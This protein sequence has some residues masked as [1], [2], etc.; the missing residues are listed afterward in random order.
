M[1]CQ[2]NSKTTKCLSAVFAAGLDW[3][4]EEAGTVRRSASRTYCHSA[5]NGT[6]RHGRDSRSHCDARVEN[7]S[8]RA[9]PGGF[10]CFAESDGTSSPHA[11][12]CDFL[13][14][15]SIGYRRLLQGQSFHSLQLP[16]A[17]ESAVLVVV[18]PGRSDLSS[19]SSSVRAPAIRDL[20]R[21]SAAW[22]RSASNGFTR[23]SIAEE[24]NGDTADGS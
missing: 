13:T 9:A 12:E 15:A 17:A 16:V 24:A 2:E 21:S 11:V 19:T 20:A 3:L 4:F 5:A 14:T 18:A 8:D 6:P 7:D 23:K 1:N 22:K 10:S